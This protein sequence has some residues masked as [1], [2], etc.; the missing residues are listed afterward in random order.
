MPY[1]HLAFDTTPFGHHEF[2]ERD[3]FECLR[4]F[5]LVPEKKIDLILC[6]GAHVH[7]MLSRLCREMH[8]GMSGVK[9]QEARPRRTRVQGRRLRIS[10]LRMSIRLKRSCDTGMMRYWDDAI[11]G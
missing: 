4:A 3:L 5:R 1:C 11:L 8:A 9:N 7:F 2:V 10:H 6:H